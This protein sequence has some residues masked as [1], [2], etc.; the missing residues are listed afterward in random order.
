MK[1]SKELR[2]IHRQ[3]IKH[4]PSCFKRGLVKWGSEKEF[5]KTTGENWYNYPGYRIG[6]LDIE[7][8]GL[9]ADFATMLTWAIKEKDGP[10][11]YDIITK[12][13]LFNGSA[14]RRLIQSVVDELGKYD[15]IVGYFSTGF[16]LPFIRTKA[17][18]YGI[19]FPHYGE[20]YH[21]DLFYTVKSKL[22]LSRKSLD[23]ACDYLGISGKTPLD[24][25]VWRRAKYGDR[26]AIQKVLEHNI[27][28]VEITEKLHNKLFPARKWIKTSV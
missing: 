8:D 4:H 6:Y 10:T 7:S 11:N 22:C 14:D 25:D 28:D 15:I 17:L 24:K 1:K 26:D 2:C 21:W 23:N 5:T 3:D 27:A 12:E 13:E 20:V 19:D 9:R 18:H 16:D